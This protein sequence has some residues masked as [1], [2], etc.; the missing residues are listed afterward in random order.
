MIKRL[1]EVCCKIDIDEYTLQDI[2]LYFE[3]YDGYILKIELDNGIIE[4]YISKTILPHLLGL[5][6]AYANRKDR[7]SYKG[8]LGFVKLKNGLINI[9]DVENNI[10]NN[11]LPVFW[12]NVKRRIEYLP[13][14][15]NT[16]QK[17]TYLKEI[18][19]EKI[20]RKSK[21]NSMYAIF[22]MVYED[23]RILYP[24]LT[25]KKISNGRLVIETFIVEEDITLLGAQPSLK[26]KKIS[27]IN[28][29]KIKQLAA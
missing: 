15:L 16:I 29:N 21:L 13:M 23:D 9:I 18:S 22:K 6:Y 25:L 7:N 28:G 1:E 14:F 20:A 12:K 8:C 11:N 4:T 10:K 17:K 5:Q 27:L 19:L 2:A 3:K 24:I 26:I